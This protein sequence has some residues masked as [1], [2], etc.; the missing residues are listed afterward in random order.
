[1]AFYLA[2]PLLNAGELILAQ[3]VRELAKLVIARKKLAYDTIITHNRF[4]FW[5]DYL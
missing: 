3:I 4:I 5:S 1:M 2:W